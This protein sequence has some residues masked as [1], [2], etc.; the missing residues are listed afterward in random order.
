MIPFKMLSTF[1]RNL[2]HVF[3]YYPASNEILA[4]IEFMSTRTTLLSDLLKYKNREI[5]HD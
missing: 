5:N 4:Q 1:N 2:N 3:L